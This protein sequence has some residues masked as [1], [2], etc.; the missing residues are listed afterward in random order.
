MVPVL[1]LAVDE[2]SCLFCEL[3]DPKQRVGLPSLAV[4]NQPT[5]AGCVDH[6]VSEP[7]S[8]TVRVIGVGL[9]K[10]CQILGE[11]VGQFLMPRNVGGLLMPV[12]FQERQLPRNL[13]TSV[14]AA[15]NRRLDF[16]LVQPDFRPCP[17]QVL[18]DAL[19]VQ[20]TVREQLAEFERGG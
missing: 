16:F 8:E 18:D 20:E 15:P 4:M 14:K 13:S 9:P 3:G 10:L 7:H 11:F 5:A 1:R 12:R 2:A 17:G 19:F 6:R